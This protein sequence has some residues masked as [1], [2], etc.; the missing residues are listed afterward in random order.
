MPTVFLIS[1]PSV[2]RNGETPDLKPLAEHGEVKVLITTGDYPTLHS[3]RCLGLIEARLADFN[4][5]TDFLA[6]AGGDTLSAVMAGALMERLGVDHFTWLKWQ[7]G[8]G[9]NGQRSDTGH[10][11]AVKVR[12][13]EGE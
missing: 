7:R 2:K 13:W 11:R 6:W 12:L 1:Q 10:Y 5:D 9:A 3:K 8:W 4:A